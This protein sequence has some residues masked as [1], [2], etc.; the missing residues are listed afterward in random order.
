MKKAQAAMEFL[1]TYG[2]AILVVI[3]AIA[4]LAYFGV[5]DP[6]RMLPQKCNFAAGT[7]CV[8]TPS[9]DATA[10][11]VTVALKN[12]LGSSIVI[13]VDSPGANSTGDCDADD[14]SQ[15]VYTAEGGSPTT[16]TTGNVT[17]ANRGSF[18][19]T[20]DCASDLSTGRFSDDIT[21]TYTSADSGMEHK[22]VGEIRGR[23]G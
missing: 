14:I 16:Y 17:V 5:L 21:F 12:S 9:I 4:A 1:M 19:I 18:V 15:I 22:A 3:A 10:D 20:F 13:N 2:W 6:G 11:T 7:D 23:A 8:E